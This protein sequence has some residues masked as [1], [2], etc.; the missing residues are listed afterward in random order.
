MKKYSKNYLSFFIFLLGII[1]I[2]LIG[3]SFINDYIAVTKEVELLHRIYQNDFTDALVLNNEESLKILLDRAKEEGKFDSVKIADKNESCSIACDRF[4]VNSADPSIGSIEYQYY[5]KISTSTALTIIL[6]LAFLYV[7]RKLFENF[8][9]IQIS[10]SKGK[11]LAEKERISKQVSHDIRSPLIALQTYFKDKLDNEEIALKALSRIE[12]IASKLGNKRFN[13]QKTVFSPLTAIN[14]LMEEYAIYENNTIKVITDE[15]SRNVKVSANITEFKAAIS[16][17]INNSLEANENPEVS[18][19]VTR[20]DKRVEISISDNGPGIK[21]P[22]SIFIEGFTT[23]GQGSGLGLYQ[24]KSFIDSLNGEISL[25]SADTGTTL[26]LSLPVHSTHPILILDDDELYLKTSELSLESQN[27]EFH[28]FNTKESLYSF[29]NDNKDSEFDLYLDQNIETENDGLE[30]KANLEKN[31]NIN[32][33]M[34]T[35]HS[36][37][38]KEAW[39]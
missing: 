6:V 12:N 2:A 4:S 8:K 22:E 3:K 31:T 29:L 24:V 33:I 39:I 17:I 1:C 9:D 18:L 28:L 13:S 11:I 14:D 32:I 21:N 30:V 26:T 5:S 34:N 38:G 37:T 27:R 10:I 15:L 20:I 23:K 35:S 25:N 36:I 16:N 7:M 19:T